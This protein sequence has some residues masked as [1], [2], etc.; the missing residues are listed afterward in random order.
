MTQIGLSFKKQLFFSCLTLGLVWGVIEL[1]CHVLT[2][3]GWLPYNMFTP[4]IYTQETV[5]YRLDLNGSPIFVDGH[6]VYRQPG[7]PVKLRSY[8]SQGFNPHDHKRFS[9]ESKDQYRI[10]FFG[11]S[12]TEGLQ[13]EGHQTFPRLIEEALSAKLDKLVSCF[14]FGVGGT[15]TY[16]HYLRY[17]TVSQKTELDHVVLCFL[18]QND[19]LNNHPQLGQ[20]FELP[21]APYFSP[22]LAKANINQNLLINKQQVVNQ[23]ILWLRRTVGLS[24]LASGTYR[25]LRQVFANGK[26]RKADIWA[27]RESWL[28]VY[29][30]PPNQAWEEA[31]QITEDVIHRFYQRVTAD[32]AQFTLLLAADSLQIGDS[33]ILAPD[34]AA[35][36]DLS[37]PNRRLKKWAFQH[38]IPFLDSL[39]YFLA[40]KTD[41]GYPYFSWKHDGH[42]AQLGHQTMADFWMDS[43]QSP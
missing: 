40:K 34:R 25:L 6:K 28:G 30:S 12:Y 32:G 19:V 26:R 9:K 39:P 43:A 5:T 33:E 17:L 18:P 21:N 41:L 8:D 42:Y 27:W 38:R 1:C 35:A 36:C 22:A 31:W 23:R 14:N 29:G 16:H 13:V 15:G 7:V 3:V 37:Y 24:F 2:L 10:G 11:D 4:V 20:Q